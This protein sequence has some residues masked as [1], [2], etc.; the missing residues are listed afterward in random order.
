[1]PVLGTLQQGS[2]LYRNKGKQ[3]MGN[4]LAAFTHHEPKPA[5]TWDSSNIDTI[6]IIGDNLHTK[7]FKHSSVTYPKMSDFPMKCEISGYEVDIH[8][9]DSY[10]GLLDSTEDCPPYFC[11]KTSLSMISK[12]AVLIASAIMKNE[13]KFYIFDPH[14]RSVDGMACSE[15]LQF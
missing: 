10:F 4:S 14:S 5:S 12:L 7:L 8:N 15:G 3:C 1:M 11:P 6:L 13:N 9:G 2:S